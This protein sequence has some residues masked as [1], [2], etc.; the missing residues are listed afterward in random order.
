MKKGLILTLATL[1]IA[2]LCTSSFAYAP[3]IGNLPDVYIGDAE[4]NEGQTIDLN[5]FRF[6]DA[7]N[8]D[9]Y[10]SGHANDEDFATTNVRWSFMA[11]ST[12]LLKI[13]DVETLTDPTNA[14]NPQDAGL[15][16]TGYPNDVTVPTEGREL[17]N[18]TFYDLVDSPEGSGPPW[19]DPTAGSE[20]N[21]I[22]TIYASNGTKADSEQIQV[23]ANLDDGIDKIS[24]PVDWEDAQDYGSPATEGWTKGLGVSDGTY[25]DAVDG[26]FYIA[27][28]STDAGSVGAAGDATDNTYGSWQSPDDDIPFVDGSLYRVKYTIRTNQSDQNSVP[29][30]RLYVEAIGDGVLA[31]A[32]GG[33]V[34]KG[35]FAPTTAGD[36]YNIYFAPPAN[37]PASVTNIRMKFEVIDFDAAE[38]GTNYLDEVSVSRKDLPSIGDAAGTVQSWSA[39]FSGWSSISLSDPFGTATL[40]NN[41]TG[42]YIETP[43]AYTTDAINYGSWSLGASSSGIAFEADR[44]YRCVYTLQSPDQSTIGKIRL[45]NQNQGGDWSAIY[46]LEPAQVQDQM[47]DADG[48]EYDV[49]F[50]SMPA[51]YTGTETDKNNMGFSWDLSDGKDTQEGTVYLTDIDLYYYDLP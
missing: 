20:L 4:D 49:F 29:N 48:E 5:F 50:E 6:S 23:V 8:F 44:L 25:I 18:A 14:I 3:I 24:F 16:L 11:D 22:I 32:G 45:I 42:M 38:S 27:T 10:V 12:G 51:L 1:A 28:H 21:E 34:G 7:F 31:A 30:C 15:E 39:P 13:N 35:I 46:E 43:A 33:R 47:P 9:L 36:D 2:L 19:P 17:S 26:A 37:L 40:G 41:S